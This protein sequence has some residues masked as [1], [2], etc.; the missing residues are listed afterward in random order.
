MRLFVGGLLFLA[1]S[2]LAATTEVKILV[3]S[4]KNQATG[5]RVF[6]ATGNFDGVEQVF[7]TTL[8]TTTMMVTGVTRQPCVDPATATFGSPALK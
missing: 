4:D 6:T 8:D 5:C 1:S 7:T 2:A 3:D